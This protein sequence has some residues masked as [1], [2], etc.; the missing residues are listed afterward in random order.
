MIRNSKFQICKNIVLLHRCWRLINGWLTARRK[1]RNLLHF[2]GRNRGHRITGPLQPRSALTYIR[3]RHRSINVT[4]RSLLFV[5]IHQRYRR[6]DKR[7]DG[8]HARSIVR[9]RAKM[10]RLT[11]RFRA[12]WYDRYREEKWT[13]QDCM[14]GYQRPDRTSGVNYKFGAPCK[15]CK[16]WS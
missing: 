14:D 16:T 4:W 13:L 5:T 1:I 10:A 11:V 8:R 9:R 2:L 6:T 7:T 12:Q 3:P 15:G